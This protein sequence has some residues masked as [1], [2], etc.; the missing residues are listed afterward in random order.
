MIGKWDA[1]FIYQWS[2]AVDIGQYMIFTHCSVNPSG[3]QVIA[4]SYDYTNGFYIY[5]FE[6]NTGNSIEVYNVGWI[7]TYSSESN[8]AWIDDN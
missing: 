5:L 3:Q 2:R 6:G 1:N 4:T 8:F 7:G